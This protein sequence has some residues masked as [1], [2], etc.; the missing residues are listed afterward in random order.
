MCGGKE[1]ILKAAKSQNSKHQGGSLHYYLTSLLPAYG[2]TPLSQVVTCKGRNDDLH[3]DIEL[4][5][6]RSY[7]PREDGTK[8]VTA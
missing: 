1:G 4:Q 5:S 7:L 8:E 6:Q 3:S 2:Q